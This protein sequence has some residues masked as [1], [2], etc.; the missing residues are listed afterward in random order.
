MDQYSYGFGLAAV[1]TILISLVL[2]LL[3]GAKDNRSKLPPG[4]WNLPVVGSLHHFVGTLP[5]HALLRLSRRYGP[6]M[7]LSVGEVS[8]VVVSTP[9]AAMEVLKTNDLVFASRPSRPTSDI[10]SCG[11]KGIIFTPYGDHW[12]LMRKI[13][14]VEVLSARQVRR[15]D[16]IMQDEIAKLV[17]SIVAASSTSPAAVID[18]SKAMVELTNNIIT[19]A[20][21]GGKCPQQETYLGELHPLLMLVGGFHLVDLFPSS[22]LVRLLSRATSHLRSCHSRIQRILEDI[23]VERKEK[24]AASD[25]AGRRGDEDLLDVLLRL[26]KEDTLNFPL[27]SEIIG[28]VIF[29]IFAAATDTSATTLEWAMSELIRNPEVMTRTK[30]EVRQISLAPGQSMITSADLGNLHYLRRVIKETLR[31]HPPAAVIRRA[32]RERCQ[33]MGYNTPKDIPVMINLFAVG[34][35]ARHWGQDAA[36]FRP[37]RFDAMN[38]EYSP[39]SQ[40]EFIPFGFGRRQCPGARMATT[41]IELVL[42]NLLYQFDW[43]IPGGASPG[44]LDMSEVFGLT[45][46]RSSNLCLQAANRRPQLH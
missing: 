5:H 46:R 6:L 27:T 42:A 4:P 8:S 38:V 23:L 34:R 37:E 39:G 1:C 21:F 10:V 35:D 44:S 31:L 9:E 11:G 32:A 29:D 7:L 19:R 22:L 30:L 3:L 28:A 18:L 43:A 25:S 16:S 12:R 17:S 45:V 40:M 26:Q 2:Y 33:V 24:E 41:T 15:I 20:V 14:I 36:E 13:C